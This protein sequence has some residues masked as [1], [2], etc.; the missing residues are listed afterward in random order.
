MY[1]A[2]LAAQGVSIRYADFEE[3]ARAARR[4]NGFV[5][6]CPSVMDWRDGPTERTGMR[7]LQALK[8]ILDGDFPERTARY[9]PALFQRLLAEFGAADTAE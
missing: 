5:Y 7:L 4:Y 8:I 2:A 9:S 1:H 6:L 3:R